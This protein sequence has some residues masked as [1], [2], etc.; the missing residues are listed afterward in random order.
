M[1]ISSTS[2]LSSASTTTRSV[3][4]RLSHDS[5]ID[6]T[7]SSVVKNALQKSIYET[8]SGN[9]ISE[10]SDKTER[11]ILTAP[12]Q[13]AFTSSKDSAS[14]SSDATSSIG[15]SIIENSVMISPETKVPTKIRVPSVVLETSIIVT[16]VAIESKELTPLLTPTKMLS[17]TLAPT[18]SFSIDTSVVRS[19]AV[20]ASIDTI[21]DAETHSTSFSEPVLFSGSFAIGSD[22]FNIDTLDKDLRSYNGELLNTFDQITSTFLDC[23][24]I[25]LI[26]DKAT[27]KVVIVFRMDNFD[28]FMIKVTDVFFDRKV[29]YNGFVVVEH[30]DDYLRSPIVDSLAR[31]SEPS[32]SISF[33]RDQARDAATRNKKIIKNSGINMDLNY[34]IFGE[35]ADRTKAARLLEIGAFDYSFNSSIQTDNIY[36]HK[37]YGIDILMSTLSS[38]LTSSVRSTR[39]APVSSLT[40]RTST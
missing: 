32:D 31:M 28:Q 25:A 23:E 4:A 18:T 21:L 11:A 27:N 13:I 19:T 37:V 30:A 15:N 26:N 22:I 10:G 40:V 9:S 7:G 38:T 29:F 35:P 33:T 1:A 17:A 5:F 24:I 3:S 36:V 8:I 39:S 12:Q 2:G 14:K 20:T 6:V 16:V 34:T